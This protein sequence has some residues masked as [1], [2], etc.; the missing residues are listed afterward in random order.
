MKRTFGRY[1]HHYNGKTNSR[2]K[3][4]LSKIHKG[5]NSSNVE[6]AFEEMN[7]LYKEII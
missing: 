2:G 1:S 6:K 7:K 4:K 5:L 3:R